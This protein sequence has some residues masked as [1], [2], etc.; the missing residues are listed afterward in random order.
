M[1]GRLFN[2]AFLHMNHGKYQSI[3]RVLKGFARLGLRMSPR[4]FGAGLP[5]RV[6]FALIA[7]LLVTACG[8]REAVDT[9]TVTGS[10]TIAPLVADAAKRYEKSHPGVRIEVQSGGSSRGIADVVSG[11]ADL[12]M[13]SRDLKDEEKDKLTAHFLAADGVCLVI[14]R[15][16]P[17]RQLDRQQLIDI[18]TKK[19]TNWKDLGGNDATIIVA[20]K[21]EGRSTLEVFLHFLGLDNADVKADLIVGEN[22]HVIKSLVGNPDTVG[23]VSI[24]TASAEEKAGT[25]IKLV[26]TDGIAPTM[27]SVRDGS[28]P[29][30]R[31]LNLVT[32]GETSHAA[33][34]FLDYMTSA[35]INDIIGKHFFVTVR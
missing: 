13:V 15:D 33:K 32:D 5:G 10:S 14:H 4:W 30:T 1:N 27:E 24:G 34:A 29:I 28:F 19:I 12:G 22:M 21:A 6:A 8:K 23:Y 31:P 16:N 26:L 20:S 3:P 18:Y 35:E 17:V 25:P 7:V 11:M 2:M 9:V